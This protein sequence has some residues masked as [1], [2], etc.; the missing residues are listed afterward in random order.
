MIATNTRTSNTLAGVVN[1]LAAAGAITKL[2]AGALV[3]DLS[4]PRRRTT[5]NELNATFGV[6]VTEGGH[7]TYTLPTQRSTT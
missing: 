1:G 4:S 6:T 5:F 7:Y 2:E 3:R